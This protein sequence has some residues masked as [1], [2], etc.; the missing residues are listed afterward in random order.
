MDAQDY[1]DTPELFKK[2]KTE[3]DI[4]E[5]IMRSNLMFWCV[6]E[7]SQHMSAIDAVSLMDRAEQ[8]FANGAFDQE[9]LDFMTTQPESF[10]WD[11][12]STTRA[13]V[14]E[15]TIEFQRHAQE[16]EMIAAEKM[17]STS[18]DDVLAQAEGDQA[19]LCN[20]RGKMH[21]WRI[22]THLQT[23]KFNDDL[24]K[25]GTTACTQYMS[26]N[27]NIYSHLTVNGK[28]LNKDNTD[29]KTRPSRYQAMVLDSVKKALATGTSDPSQIFVVHVLDF[30][31]LQNLQPSL[32]GD[33]MAAVGTMLVGSDNHVCFC[34]LPTAFGGCSGQHA[35]KHRRQIE[36]AFLKYGLDL[37]ITSSI[38]FAKHD[39][40]SDRRCLSNWAFLVCKDSNSNAF[41]NSGFAKGHCGTE[42]SPLIRTK[43]MCA[44][45]V[46]GG[47]NLPDTV[48]KQDLTR[49]CKTV[50][51]NE[52][53][54]QRGTAAD[55]QILLSLLHGAD[56]IPANGLVVVIDWYPN[57]GNEWVGAVKNLQVAKLSGS[58]SQLPCKIVGVCFA[59]SPDMA[60]NFESRL[61]QEL[62]TEWFAEKI[63]LPGAGRIPSKTISPDELV[64]KPAQPPMKIGWL[65][66]N[67]ENEPT[68]GFASTIGDRFKSNSTLQARW[69]ARCVLHGFHVYLF[70]LMPFHLLLTLFVT[71][72]LTS[73][74]QLCFPV[75]VLKHSICET[76]SIVSLLRLC[77]TT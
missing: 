6:A 23:S 29:P 56:T 57:A 35:V 39:T 63:S 10:T 8:D 34:T 16:K 20:Y 13:G 66:Q 43:D 15:N 40:E 52:R 54:R 32:F 62:Y 55:E 37:G 2:A 73:H 31:V 11:M 5:L 64:P 25:K 30:V 70:H 72:T 60:M 42:G 1:E 74:I 3:G 50:S 67:A 65:G 68:L 53:H 46:T 76:S 48:T 22:Q 44:V 47:A 58:P 26:T 36:D 9:L 18:F 45:E 24:R 21:S 38:S 12:L 71:S 69:E 14:E 28:A 51:L 59:E 27:L 61:H 41:R 77:I 75:L 17:L 7:G 49:G 4:N 33:I 19:R